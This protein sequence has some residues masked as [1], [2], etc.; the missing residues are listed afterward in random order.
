MH[1]LAQAALAALSRPGDGLRAYDLP[2][3]ET[4]PYREMVS[5]VLSA[6]QPPARLGV[7]PGPLFTLAAEFARRLGVQDA[8]PAVL[9]RM[10]Q[11]LAFDAAGA[12]RDL[13]YAPRPFRPDAAMFA[14]T[15]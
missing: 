14:R 13:G 2:G 9:A 3:G 11:D 15:P 5:R 6:L 1:R 12:R 10:R 4:L 8:G 7:L